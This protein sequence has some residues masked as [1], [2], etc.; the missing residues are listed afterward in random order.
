LYSS[1]LK[2]RL[3]IENF[4]TNFEFFYPGKNNIDENQRIPFFGRETIELSQEIMASLDIH[5]IYK[6]LLELR[7]LAKIP[8]GRMH[9]G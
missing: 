9:G 4:R 1:H 3:K 8:R 2:G 5:L 7:E 6:G